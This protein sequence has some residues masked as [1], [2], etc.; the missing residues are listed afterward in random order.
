MCP[1]VAVGSAGLRPSQR[2][3]ALTGLVGD[4]NCWLGPQLGLWVRTLHTAS[5]VAGASSQPGGGTPR[6]NILKKKNQVEAVLFFM[7]ECRRSHRIT[8]AFLYGLRQ[9]QGSIR[10]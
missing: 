1:I 6:A 9:S 7:M 10:I 2:A 8:C 5:H 4:T 3:S